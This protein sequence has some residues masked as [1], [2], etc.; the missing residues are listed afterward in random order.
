VG[1]LYYPTS[2]KAQVNFKVVVN[3]CVVTKYTAPADYKWDY[4]VGNKQ[5]NYIFNFD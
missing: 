3:P 2:T 4:V 5:A 1:L